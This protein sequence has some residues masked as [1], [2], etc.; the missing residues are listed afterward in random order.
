MEEEIHS[1]WKHRC[2]EY[3]KISK[4]NKFSPATYVPTYISECIDSLVTRDFSPVRKKK[5]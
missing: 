4:A 1:R 3:W 5:V 2:E